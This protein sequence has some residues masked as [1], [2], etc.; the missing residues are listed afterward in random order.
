MSEW[1]DA[2]AYSNLQ[3]SSAIRVDLADAEGAVHRVAVVRI[4]DQLYAIGDR[5]SHADVSLAEGTVYDDE[6][7]LECIKHG[8]LF[9]LMNGEAIT[10]P[11][12]RSV[13]V[14][15]VRRDGD[16]ILVRVPG[17]IKVATPNDPT[18]NAWSSASSET[19]AEAKQGP[20]A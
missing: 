16:R 13:P 3:P 11:A 18:T 15:D 5:C 8:S 20:A 6:C 1:I 2:L 17:E 10:F 12:T 4:E 9:S 19:A 7:Q 14:F